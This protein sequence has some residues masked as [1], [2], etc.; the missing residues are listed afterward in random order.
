MTKWDYITRE[1]KVNNLDLQLLGE[2]G[3]ELV[4][5]VVLMQETGMRDARLKMFF[6]RRK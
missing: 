6:K 5:V 3:W 1:D 2:K 4:S